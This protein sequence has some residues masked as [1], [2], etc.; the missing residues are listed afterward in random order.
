MMYLTFIKKT[1]FRLGSVPVLLVS[2]SVFYTIAKIMEYT[3]WNKMHIVQE[4]M[5][6]ACD[7]AL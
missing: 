2:V 4:C 3:G 1:E 6:F 5:V 7:I